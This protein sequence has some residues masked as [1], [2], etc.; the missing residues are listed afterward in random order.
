LIRLSPIAGIILSALIFGGCGTHRQA[1]V[2]NEAKKESAQTVPKK[3]PD[4]TAEAID[5]TQ[6]SL[7]DFKG[8][9]IVLQFWEMECDGCIMELPALGNMFEEYLYRGFTVVGIIL[10]KGYSRSIVRKFCQENRVRFPNALLLENVSISN[11]Y[12]TKFVTPT[13]YFIDRKGN[14]RYKIEGLA[15]TDELTGY[16]EALLRE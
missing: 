6:F 3:A 12:G 14:I 11:S 16:A 1:P 5:G 10:D 8:K 4:F 2:S 13:T 7:S 9:V 15:K